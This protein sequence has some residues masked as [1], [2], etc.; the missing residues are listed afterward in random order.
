MGIIILSLFFIEGFADTIQRD[1]I[2]RARGHL[3]PEFR[4]KTAGIFKR[5]KIVRED[6][7][8]EDEKGL[9]YRDIAKIMERIRFVLWIAWAIFFVVIA[10]I[11]FW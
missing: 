4:T 8:Y 1:Y 6:E 11:F 5:Y 2:A 9:K 10:P 3:K 7:A